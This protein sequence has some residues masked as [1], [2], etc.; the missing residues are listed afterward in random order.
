M[1]LSHGALLFMD[2]DVFLS[3]NVGR[4]LTLWGNL[5]RA[6]SGRFFLARDFISD[7]YLLFRGE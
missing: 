5:N 6:L 2:E 4:L 1:R 7:D 3:S